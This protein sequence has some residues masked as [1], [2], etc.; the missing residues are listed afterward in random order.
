[1]RHLLLLAFAIT[2]LSAG[3]PPKWAAMDYG[4]AFGCSLQ[5]GKEYVLRALIVRLD[6]EKQTYVAYDL[7]TMRVAAMWTGGF[8][9]YKGVIFNGEHHAQPKPAGTMIFTNSVGPGWAKDGSF[10]DPRPEYKAAYNVPTGGSELTREGQ[11][12]PKEWIDY[13]GYY[14]HG[15]EV[16]LSYVANGCA[17]LERPALVAGTATTLSR[18]LSIGPLKNAQRIH[19]G[20]RSFHD[21]GRPTGNATFETIGDEQVLAV[22]SSDLPNTV[23]VELGEHTRLGRW[24]EPV[25]RTKGGPLRW[26]QTITTQG[27]L[28]TGDG[29]YVVDALNPPDDNP[30]KSWIRFGGIDFFAD[31][32]RAAL[33][34]WSGDV[35]IVS[36]IDAELKTLTWKRYA[37]GLYQP[38]GLKIV[39]GKVLC[40][41]RD[42]IVRLHDLNDD[43][44]ADFYESFN[45]DMHL[46]RHFHEFALDLQSDPQGNLYFAKGATPGRGGPNFDLWSISNGGY[47]RLSPDG[48][49]LDVVARGLRAPN[50][51]GVGPH[52]EMVSGDNQGSWVPVCPINRIREGGFVGIPDGV[53]GPIKPTKRDDPIVWIPYDIDNSSGG[54]VWVPDNRWG[55]FAG[56]MLHLSYGKC[57]LFAAMTQTIGDTMQG[58]LAKF[59]LT[60]ASGVMRARFNAADGQLYVCGLRGWQTTAARDG[61]FQRVRFTGKAVRMPIGWAVTKTGIELTFTDALDKAV[62]EDVG[63]YAIEQFNIRWAAAYGSPELSV[64]DPAKQGRDKVEVASAKLKDDGRTVVLAIPGLKPVNCQV[65]K[66]KIAAADG[67]PIATMVWGTINAMP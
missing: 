11:P 46:T 60:F 49:K 35:W 3:E 55:P 25:E 10:A 26:A 7:E 28:G 61:C 43:G 9:D 17:V 48:K 57:S 39:D 2:A 23:T 66:L 14:L 37:T 56:S 1:M 58:A 65:I 21:P 53:P 22:G 19:L 12:M 36:G 44:E 27:A 6:K 31:G 29:P 62:A 24:K 41:C 47:F 15:D 33:C 67:T 8:I 13:R 30:W 63:N 64:A 54:Q 32:K 51:I 4:P 20:V 45:S 50:G 42:R 59:P 38:L 18:E 52:G 40:T 5:I 34:T 16:V